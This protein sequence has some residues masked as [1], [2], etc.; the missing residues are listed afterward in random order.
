MASFDDL[1]ERV[2]Q[3][4]D[5]QG[6]NKG[7]GNSSWDDSPSGQKYWEDIRK[8]RTDLEVGKQTGQNAL[9]LEQEKEKGSL[10]R[11]NIAAGSSKYKADTEAGAHRYAS[12]KTFEAAHDKVTG[13]PEEQKNKY[14]MKVISSP[15]ASTQ[16]PEA[17]NAMVDSFNNKPI[18]SEEAKKTY[19]KPDP[20]S[21]STSS[22]ITKP[23]DDTTVVGKPEDELKRKKKEVESGISLI[24]SREKNWWDRSAKPWLD[25]LDKKT[26]L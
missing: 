24:G 8:R 9:N 15:W 7:G 1:I 22:A 14:R 11:E 25:E 5:K 21:V 2:L 18:D 12:D 17:I 3:S 4:I 6:S 20:S 16:S 19:I 23:I 26:G 10:A 13:T